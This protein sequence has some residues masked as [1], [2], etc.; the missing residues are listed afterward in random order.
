MTFTKTPGTSA[1]TMYETPSSM[2]LNPG[3]EVKVVARRPA[4]PHP[5]IML[6][7]ATSLTACTKT[8]SS[9]GSSWAMSSAPSVEGVM[10]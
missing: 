1:P 2:R 8:P 9:F 6:T 10:G 4:P 7:V 3:D 5:Y